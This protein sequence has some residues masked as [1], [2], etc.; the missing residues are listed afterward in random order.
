MTSPTVE[1]Q[2]ATVGPP[3]GAGWGADRTIRAVQDRS[4][5]IKN[6]RG[7]RY[8]A[9][10]PG[11][12]ARDRP[13]SRVRAPSLTPSERLWSGSWPG[14][15]SFPRYLLGAR[16]PGAAPWHATPAALVVATTAPT[17]LAG[18]TLLGLLPG[19]VYLDAWV[20][21][22]EVVRDEHYAPS[23]SPAARTGRESRRAEMIRPPLT[24]RG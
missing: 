1:A 17:V 4:R 16:V 10:S 8:L 6:V 15:L 11:H 20:L 12:Q 22:V 2:P 5:T 9:D 18:C 14:S 23:D 3:W 21:L 19:T 13:H 24:R 7:G